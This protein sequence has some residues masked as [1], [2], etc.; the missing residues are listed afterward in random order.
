MDK[1]FK[2]RWFFSGL[3]Q[4]VVTK[5][6]FFGA[7]NVDAAAPYL[8]DF[9]SMADSL[10]EI[11][12]GFDEDGYDIHTVLPIQVGTS[13]PSI[14]KNNSYLGDYSYSLTRGAIVIGKKRTD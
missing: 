11:I 13:E 12:S 4:G 1:K 10:C 8:P 2:S 14:T 9:Q 5:H 7:K 3:G 6:G